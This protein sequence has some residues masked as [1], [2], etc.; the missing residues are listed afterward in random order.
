MMDIYIQHSLL[1]TYIFLTRSMLSPGSRDCEIAALEI[2]EAHATSENARLLPA[3]TSNF[4][5]CP[6]YFLKKRCDNTRC[7]RYSSL[8]LL[9]SSRGTLPR[10]R[11]VSH[12]VWDNAEHTCPSQSCYYFFLETDF[13]TAS[14]SPC[15]DIS[16]YAMYI[17]TGPYVWE[18]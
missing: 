18:S 11:C 5:H 13:G 15:V 6:S 4:H 2:R 17:L 3:Q 1:S 16:R 12:D 9:E 7:L 10:L 14:I 8:A